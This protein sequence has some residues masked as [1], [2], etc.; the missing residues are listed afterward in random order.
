MSTWLH[1]IERASIERFVRESE[2]AFR[3]K[4]VL[5]W[6]C[7]KQP[8]REIVELAGGI[9]LP[10][11]RADLPANVSGDDFGQEMDVLHEA[12]ADTIL[13]TQVIQY[14]PDP[15]NLL[16]YLRTLTI[17]GGRLLITGPTTWPVVEPEDLHRYT[18]AGIKA[19]L[20]ETGWEV[21]L[22]YER[23]SFAKE[24]ITFPVGWAVEAQR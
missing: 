19:L 7:G 1:E 18:L 22:G 6:G 4:S 8:Y 23:A 24:R 2:H 14:V 20:K 10:W 5:D 16:D 12:M 21:Q 15:L 9:Y 17:Q 13:C 11:D 3:D